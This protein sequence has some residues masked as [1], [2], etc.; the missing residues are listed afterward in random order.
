MKSEFVELNYC[1]LG[2]GHGIKNYTK[3]KEEDDILN[4]LKN[5]SLYKIFSFDKWRITS[6]LNT[7]FYL[8]DSHEDFNSN[9]RIL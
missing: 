7:I 1:Y 4:I 5:Q 8:G 2:I 3:L 9:Y 6:E